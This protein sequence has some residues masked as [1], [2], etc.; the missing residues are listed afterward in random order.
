MTAQQK[1]RKRQARIR[2][3]KPAGQ[4]GRHFL[5]LPSP[6]ATSSAPRTWRASGLLAAQAATSMQPR[7]WAASTISA[8]VPGACCA[9]WPSTTSC[10]RAIQSPRSGRIQSCCWTRSYACVRSHRLCQCSGP[11]FCQPGSSRTL[12][13][14]IRYKIG[15]NRCIS[16]NG[17][18]QC[19]MRC[20]SLAIRA[21]ISW[22]KATYA[23]APLD[24][25]SKTTPG[26]P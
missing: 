19:R 20:Q 23:S 12:V 8:G 4:R 2:G 15:S 6:G 24:A 26:T 1:C 5:A 3:L 7:L 16:G 14:V 9:T 17:P 21:T 25:G 22:A 18:W 10:K 11:E 13:R